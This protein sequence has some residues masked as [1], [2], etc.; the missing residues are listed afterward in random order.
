M[1]SKSARCA[2]WGPRSSAARPS[3]VGFACRSPRLPTGSNGWGIAASPSSPLSQ[4]SPTRRSPSRSRPNT[5]SQA[6]RLGVCVRRSSPRS[7]L[8]RNT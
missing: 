2:R 3:V 1:S 4:M 8:S 6:S 7:H 5:R